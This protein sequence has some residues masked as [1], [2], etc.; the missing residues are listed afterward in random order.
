MV[1]FMRAESSLFCAH[2]NSPFKSRWESLWALIRAATAFS[3]SVC[4]ICP[5]GHDIIFPKT[6]DI[7]YAGGGGASS[8]FYLT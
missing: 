5:R 1:R 2:R 6:G 4:N 3:Y 7:S 8:V